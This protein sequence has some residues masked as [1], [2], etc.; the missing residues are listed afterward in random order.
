M[1]QIKTIKLLC[2]NSIYVYWFE[3]KSD[4]ITCII[5]FAQY[6]IDKH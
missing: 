6:I 1:Q 3:N 5:L 4:I 2:D